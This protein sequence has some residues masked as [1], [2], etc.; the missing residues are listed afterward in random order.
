M[1]RLRVF[2]PDGAQQDSVM[3]RA[4]FVGVGVANSARY[5]LREVPIALAF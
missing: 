4:E 5:V 3:Y 2:R 1:V